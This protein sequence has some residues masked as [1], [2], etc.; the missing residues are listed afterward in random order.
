MMAILA[1]AIMVGGFGAARLIAELARPEVRATGT[2]PASVVPIVLPD[3]DAPGRDVPGLPRYPGAVRTDFGQGER[4]RAT[5]T[6]VAY[7]LRG[8]RNEVRSFYVD[9]FRERGWQIVDLEFSGGTW[10]FAIERGQRQATVEVA[11]DGGLVQVRLE[12]TRTLPDP[13]PQ[14]TPKPQPPAPP[15]PPPPGD[16]D[17]DDG[18]DDD[19]DDDGEGGDD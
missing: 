11:S 12:V 3:R 5:V 1:I 15:G 7:A 2:P 10:T 9:A 6:R 18:D 14:P 8:S 16:D 4:A 19:D 13:T 17:D